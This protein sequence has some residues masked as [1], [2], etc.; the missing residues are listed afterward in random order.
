MEIVSKGDNAL[1]ALGNATIVRNGNTGWFR[2]GNGNARDIRNYETSMVR[3]YDLLFIAKNAKNLSQLESRLDEIRG[4]LDVYLVRGVSP[5]GVL[6]RLSFGR[7]TGNLLRVL[8]LTD[9]AVGR[10][11]SRIDFFDFDEFDGA[12]YPRRWVI[13]TPISYERVQVESVQHN[14]AVD[15]SR[16]ARPAGR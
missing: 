11:P 14:A 9:T 13:R 16:F 3:G 4:G 1:L 5:E 15:D 7:E 2:A 12:M 8:A 6:V 10:N